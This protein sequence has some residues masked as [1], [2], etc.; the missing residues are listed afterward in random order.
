MD[1]GYYLIGFSANGAKLA[2]P[3]IF[4]AIAWSTERV[5]RQTLEKIQPVK[6]K[7]GLLPPWYDV[8]TPAELQFLFDYLFGMRL[9]GETVPAPLTDGELH[10]Y[11]SDLS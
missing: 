11:L 5:F 4:E 1:G 8:D 10:K 3:T 6:A 7:L 2:I 9:A